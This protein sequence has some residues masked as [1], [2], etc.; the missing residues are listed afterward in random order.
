VLLKFLH[1]TDYRVFFHV[2]HWGGASSPGGYSIDV[3]INSEG[4]INAFAPDLAKLS[5]AEQQYWASYSSLPNGEI[6]EEM[7][8]TRMQQR[9]PNSPGVIDLVQ[10]ALDSL[11]AAFKRRYASDLFDEGTPSDSD[12]NHLSVGPIGR[13][14]TEVFD[15]SKELYKWTIERMQ[16]RSLRTALERKAE[17][18]KDWK[19]IKLISVLLDLRGL[20]SNDTQMVVGPLYGLNELRI[21]SAH[22]A[23]PDLDEIFKRMGTTTA[24]KNPREA[25]TACGDLVANSLT[26]FGQAL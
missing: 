22:T 24:P 1:A 17:I 19:Q 23:P 25:W 4:L 14:F 15:L 16:T 26:L 2:R 10:D 11:S 21:A 18:N 3:G 7:F 13:D 12:L 6:C 8:Q 20:N 5:T 9:P